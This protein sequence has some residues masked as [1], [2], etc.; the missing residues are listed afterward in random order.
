MVR[1]LLIHLNA[2]LCVRSR[3]TK[4]KPRPHPNLILS[5]VAVFNYNRMWADDCVLFL[6]ASCVTKTEV[7]MN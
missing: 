5:C 2:T 4:G 7:A 3:L 6:C 1:I